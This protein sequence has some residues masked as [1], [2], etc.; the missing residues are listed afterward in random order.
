MRS[1]HVSPCVRQSLAACHPA[2]PQEPPTLSPWYR[3]FHLL[4]LVHDC[5]PWCPSPP[6]EPS[7]HPV[8]FSP[9][10]LPYSRAIRGISYALRASAIAWA[11]EEARRACGR[12]VALL[13]DVCTQRGS[14]DAASAVGAARR[15]EPLPEQGLHGTMTRHG[16]ASLMTT[17]RLSIASRGTGEGVTACDHGNLL[18][19]A[20]D[21]ASAIFTIDARTTIALEDGLCT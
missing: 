18:H 13:Q 6:G 8:A 19:A 12:G 10:R 1:R 9:A 15:R 2:T 3:P 21:C 14:P 20:R 7:P 16:A 17:S 5:Q 11:A 4:T